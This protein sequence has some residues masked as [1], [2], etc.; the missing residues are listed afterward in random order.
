MGRYR[1][2]LLIHSNCICSYVGGGG[3]YSYGYVWVDQQ[4]TPKEP[5]EPGA[6]EEEETLGGISRVTRSICR[7]RPKTLSLS[8]SPKDIYVARYP[9]VPQVY[10]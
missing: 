2:L 6:E 3:I 1:G 5:A 4:I 9:F 8:L 10:V 7:D